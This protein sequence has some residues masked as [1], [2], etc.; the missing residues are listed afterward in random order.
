[1]KRYQRRSFALW[2]KRGEEEEETFCRGCALWK[3]RVEE[4]EGFASN[5]VG[6]TSGVWRVARVET[7]LCHKIFPLWEG[8]VWGNGVWGPH[9]FSHFLFSPTFFPNKQRKMFSLVPFSL[10]IFLPLSFSS[11]PSRP[12]VFWWK[13]RF[14]PFSYFWGIFAP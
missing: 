5:R 9:F 2:K 6:E 4:E 11:Q 7:Q 3:E 13:S 1:M 12:L 10:P 14:T 8:K